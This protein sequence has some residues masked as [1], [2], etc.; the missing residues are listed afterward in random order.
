MNRFNFSNFGFNGR[1]GSS[2]GNYNA[3]SRQQ[4]PAFGRG[5]FNNSYER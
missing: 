3:N 2:N 4:P 1:R 5:G